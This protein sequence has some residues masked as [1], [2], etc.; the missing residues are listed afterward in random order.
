MLVTWT[1][2]TDNEQGFRIR[3]DGTLIG[4]VPAN[5]SSFADQDP[6]FLGTKHDY[7]VTAVLDGPATIESV[8]ACDS[9]IGGDSTMAAPANF[10][11][12]LDT[13]DD[14]VELSWSDTAVETGY[15]IYRD[16]TLIAEP[17]A[18]E[19]LYDDKGASP[20]V[21]HAYMLLAVS[22]PD[23][24]RG[25]SGGLSPARNAVGR[26]S[27]VL[28][29]TRVTASNGTAED[30]VDV[31]WE[32]SST[33]AVLFKVYRDGVPIKTAPGL[34]RSCPDEDVDTGKH[35]YCV[36]AVTAS[37]VESGRTCDGD[38]VGYRKILAPGSVQ[39]SDNTFEQQTEITWTDRSRVEA[40]YRIFRRPA[41]G[42]A[43]VLIDSTR[44]GGTSYDDTTGTPG[45]DYLYGVI[46]F[47]G[48]GVSDTAADYGERTIKTPSRV[49]V[50]DGTYEDHVEVTWQDNSDWEL[51]FRIYRRATGSAADSVLAGN[52]AANRNSFVDD[53]SVLPLTL[54]TDYTYYVTA[55]DNRG[56]SAADS[57]SGGSTHILAPGSVS[58]SDTYPDRVVVTWVD[59]SNLETAY[60]LLRDDGAYFLLP[61]GTTSF[62]D[63]T[64]GASAA[65]EYCVT[66]LAP[67]DSSETRCDFGGRAL[68]AA[69]TADRDYEGTFPMPYPNNW[70][71]PGG[72]IDA[73]SQFGFAVAA[74]TE[75]AA[76]GDWAASTPTDDN[77]ASC[78]ACLLSSRAGAVFTYQFTGG[79]WSVFGTPVFPS[80][81]YNQTDIFSGNADLDN[82][83]E[84][85][86]GFGY[87]VD[88]DSRDRYMIVG[89]PSAT[90]G[91]TGSGGRFGR[92]YI[93]E[94][95]AAGWTNPQELV[96]PEAFD[97]TQHWG[98]GC[99]VAI[100]GDYAAVL[101]VGLPYADS[102]PTDGALNGYIRSYLVVF[103][104]D[105]S[106]SAWTAQT[107][108][109]GYKEIS[110]LLVAPQDFGYSFGPYVA[111]NGPPTGRR[112]AMSADRIVVGSDIQGYYFDKSPAGVWGSYQHVTL[113]LGPIYSVDVD[114]ATD[115]M[116]FCGTNAQGGS[117][118]VIQDPDG[119][120]TTLPYGANA[121]PFQAVIRDNVLFMAQSADTAGSNQLASRGEEG[122]QESQTMAR[123]DNSFLS[124]SSGR[125]STRLG[126]DHLLTGTW[127]NSS[128]LSLPLLR[129]STGTVYYRAVPSNPAEVTAADAATRN[130]I[131]IRWADRSHVEDG[132]KVYR[133]GM[134]VNTTGPG[135]QRY[136]DADAV[137]GRT[138]EYRIAAFTNDGYDPGLV[139][140]ADYGR[141]L[142]NGAIGGR[143]S[144]TIGAGVDSVTV[145]LDPSPNSGLL[146]DGSGGYLVTDAF[147]S[148]PTGTPGTNDPWD[149][150]TVEFWVNPVETGQSRMLVEKQGRFRIGLDASGNL[151]VDLGAVWTTSVHPS[152][153]E[154]H[155]VA[156]V[157][158]STGKIY[159]D[160]SLADSGSWGAYRDM[161]SPAPWTLGAHFAGASGY[162]ELFKGRLDEVRAWSKERTAAQIQSRMGNPL[163][164]NEPGLAAYWPMDQL[165]GPAAEDLAGDHY[166]HLH[167]GVHWT[168]E[169]SPVEFCAVTDL[170]GNYS[171]PNIRYGK[172]EEFRVVPAKAGRT[173]QPE[174]KTI[175]LNP[176]TS[177]QNEVSFNDITSY[178]VAGR[179]AFKG[180]SC[181][182]EGVRLFVDDKEIGRTGRDGTYA[183]SVDPGTR[184]I[185]PVLDG[186]TFSPAQVEVTADR[187]LDGIDF[188]DLTLRHLSG[189]VGG[190]CEGVSVG[191]VTLEIKSSD[192]CLT[193]TLT[194]TTG[195]DELLP[196][197]KYQVTV[198]GVA[199]VPAGLNRIA[200]ERF[201][202]DLGSQEADLTAQADTL[203]MV[204]TAPLRI[205]V[206]NLPALACTELLLP[207]GVKGALPDAI[208][209]QMQ[210]VPLTID[211]EEDYGSNFLCPLDTATV[212]IYDEVIDAADPVTVPLSRGEAQYETAGNTPN[213][214]PGRTDVDGGNRSYQKALTI[215]VQ[216]PGRDPTV[217]TLWFVVTGHRPRAATFS[218]VAQG[219]PVMILRDPP[220]DHSYSYIEKNESTCTNITNVVQTS[221]NL[222]TENKI[223]L[224]Q[225]FS[226][227]FGYL[228][229]FDIEVAKVFA[230]LEVGASLTSDNQLQICTTA[231][232][233]IKTSDLQTFIGEDG[234]VYVGVGLNFSF[235]KT[236]VI[237]APVDGTTCTI[238][239]SVST[240]IGV[241]GV[242]TA[243]QYTQEHIR[244]V[245]I[246]QQ[247]ELADS[248]L[249]ENKTG[250]AAVWQSSA[251]TYKRWLAL[252]DSLRTVAPLVK[253]RSFSAG[254]DEEYSETSTRSSSFQFTTSLWTQK[255][256]AFGYSFDL[257]GNGV[258][259]QLGTTLKFTA[260]VGAG[261][262]STSSRTVGYVL[263]DDDIGDY[264]TVDVK[265]DPVYGTPIF[266]VS[267]IG[268]LGRTSCPWEPWYDPTTGEPRTQPRDGSIVNGVP[269]G[270]TFQL[271][272][273]AQDDV[274]PSQAAAFQLFL[275]N[276]SD[277]DE[278]REFLIYPDQTSNPGGALMKINGS[279]FA[280]GVSFFLQ[281]RET[282]EATLTIERGPR[283]YDY[284]DLRIIS[285]PAC[286]WDNWR[287][288][289][290]LQLADTLSFDVSFTAPCSDISLFE[291]KSGWTV[292]SA[293]ADTLAIGLIDFSRAIGGPNDSKIVTDAIGA[294]YRRSGTDDTPT[295]I[296]RLTDADG[297]DTIDGQPALD[298]G[299]EPVTWQ[300]PASLAD[301]R[302]DILGWTECG[303]VTFYTATATGTV[304]RHSPAPLR[305]PEPADGL[306]SLGESISITFNEGIQ[307][308]SVS[309]DSA[310]L[311]HKIAGTW[312][313]VTSGVTTAC[314]ASGT[315]TFMPSATALASFEGDSVRAT[316]TGIKDLSGNRSAPVTWSFL[317]STSAFAWT[318]NSVIRDVS[319]GEADQFVVNL[320]NGLGTDAALSFE[321]PGSGPL[322]GW[323]SVDAPPDT[324]RTA[325][326]RTIRFDVAPTLAVG[327]SNTATVYAVATVGAAVTKTPL[328]VR[329]DVGCTEPDWT[330]NPADYE[331]SM[332]LVAVFRSQLG[333]SVFTSPAH[334]IAAFVG[335]QVRGTAAPDSLDSGRVYFT[336][337]SNRQAGEII[338]FKL[339]DADSCLTYQAADKAYLFAADSLIGSASTPE[340][341]VALLTPPLNVQEIPVQAGWTWVSFNRKGSFGLGTNFVL[342]D[343]NPAEGDV[344][345]GQADFSTYS[346][347]TGW[348][349]SLGTLDNVSGYM[350]RTSSAG[351]IR[352]D[353]GAALIGSAETQVD[354]GAGWN[355]I[356][357]PAQCDTTLAAAL[358]F[359]PDEGDRIK[360]QFEFAEYSSGQWVGSL[361]TM[362]PGRGY[363]IRVANPHTFQFPLVAPCPS[364]PAAPA[365]LPAA[366]PGGAVAL[367]GRAGGALRPAVEP[368]GAGGVG[369]AAAGG[370]G[371]GWQVNPRSFENNMTVVAELKLSDAGVPSPDMVVAALVGDEVRGLASPRYVPSLGKYLVFLMAYSNVASGEDLRFQIYDP[372]SGDVLDVAGRVPF[373]ADQGKGSVAEPVV[374]TAG[375]PVDG[376]LR[377]LELGPLRPNPFRAGAATGRIGYRLAVDGPVRLQVYDLAGRLV[378]TLVD[379]VQPAG[380]YEVL[381]QPQ[382][383]VSGIYFYKLQ[384]G[385]KSM[386]R[387]MVVLN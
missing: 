13:Y 293:S 290:A 355:W 247:E 53:G 60:S 66:A 39:A 176:E 178:T 58:A 149:P 147:G 321:G 272:P 34:A 347:D 128:I 173:F 127:L 374:L 365:V 97:V 211:V 350:L 112:L 373:G 287:N 77:L 201:F 130:G 273:P 119:T 304:D 122:W 98:F 274:D 316:V 95:N 123:P 330:V 241:D 298:V 214:F 251:D 158:N 339:W 297:S 206:S 186:R 358:N 283:K 382:G 190:R 307:C 336:I 103:K 104:K 101:T 32:S 318:R 260:D 42:G 315:V 63:P 195:Y 200:V 378:D 35:L 46:A 244:D 169:S 74:G 205:Q 146:F 52:V 229:R 238:V 151:F 255:E 345:K 37:G 328:S 117:E 134:L 243:F 380:Q 21:A 237:D 49:R 296:K 212:T 75:F 217:K 349:G 59:R 362:Q 242:E 162:N 88:V 83:D 163:T 192:G 165:E 223:K 2:Q 29:P 85:R 256:Q 288:G 295:V 215:S 50:S 86:F 210:R 248:A 87:S 199:N 160:G 348:V 62:T 301:G 5:T 289:G 184:V 246:P 161:V 245:L 57:A 105:P 325:E 375:L 383:L 367:A 67:P 183:I 15:E 291:P 262:S 17:G 111:L 78:G 254:A 174:F 354:L 219:I 284:S 33:T 196:P 226:V 25:L 204:Y 228:S 312:T 36:A 270:A 38:S 249:A 386:T 276:T 167:G 144:T 334:R 140:E 343:L 213:I 142:P 91:S 121:Q 253:N 239:P 41:G 279:A 8:A 203:D 116:T 331:Y 335:S 28:A 73:S 12:T 150:V 344:I 263:S 191:D 227:G 240:T 47:D 26:R 341:I 168:S 197:Q 182:A 81:A 322:P 125:I 236:D 372:R 136:D 92:A 139:A 282:Q 157:L 185:K 232:D 266:D 305:T 327:S 221:R 80:V 31:T 294:S 285:A 152:P 141:T 371:A 222:R 271:Q 11:A 30:K 133:D 7:C 364:L 202:A 1:D 234:N 370:T 156:V 94:R 69:S 138:Y 268:T 337:Y 361:R 261:T 257:A 326:V 323:L 106:S 145:C 171:I 40:G 100:E 10:R 313:R 193:R 359:A 235:A 342:G 143:V 320:S 20:G 353:G 70:Q 96:F 89:D 387:K 79:K 124:T 172:G 9:G 188:S 71:V 132:Y 329:V 48:T 126:S 269:E 208:I 231:L 357:D 177:V 23:S 19:V 164:G 324:I 302:Y 259:G 225:K 198:T 14:K 115:V 76:V 252:N 84:S 110:D 137:P 220:G 384:S 376:G 24:V 6:G 233:R 311:E 309:A 366:G 108:S 352:L 155:H 209:N 275:T 216:V 18:D 264:F 369:L 303:G 381:Y 61:A 332:N 120:S 55:Y 72:A 16:G 65:Q 159:L 175:S 278:A 99:Q 267:T 377:K 306:L 265:D 109:N 258:S 148:T 22:A 68:P 218:T 317:V 93:Y 194:T 107:L 118:V 281:P 189:R 333:D 113:P 64:G 166:A 187:N 299:G 154:W 346:Q 363:K 308:A 181:G 314:S 44:A 153:G 179:I 300:L 280:G 319:A 170:Q 230:N 379:R 43:T 207:G 368:V 45:V 180:A 286:E 135:V 310:Y 356:G 3:R 338:R 4:T 54:G 129:L 131:A 360:S 51:G 292:N 224:G 27:V 277:S 385:G 340:S 56:L 351:T 102:T 250:Q 82:V 90:S 114:R